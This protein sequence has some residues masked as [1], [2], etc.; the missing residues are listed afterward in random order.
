MAFQLLDSSG[1]APPDQT[2]DDAWG[3]HI[4]SSH[5]EIA[6]V[7]GEI[8]CAMSIEGYGDSD[9]F[10]VHMSLH[11]AIVNALTHGNR[12][13]PSRVILVRCRVTDLDVLA[14]VEDQGN[15]FDPRQ[16]PDPRLPANLDRPRGRGLLM[17]QHFMTWVAFNKKGNCVRL[18][19]SR[20][21]VDES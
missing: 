6:P 3:W 1:T 4:L 5:D 7:I 20:T 16:V 12:C 11:E 15:G 13:D 19:K 21:N 18:F 14:E 10:A 17:M 8:V 9:I 2:I